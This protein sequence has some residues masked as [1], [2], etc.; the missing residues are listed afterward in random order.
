MK[1]G[2]RSRLFDSL[3]AALRLTNGNVAVDVI[4]DKMLQFSENFSCPYC[5]FT[6]GELEPRI[7]SFNAP[8]GACP[9]CDG[10]GV[11]LEVDKDLVIPDDTKTLNEGAL[12]PWNPISSKY[13]PTMLQQAC[14][15]FGIDMD[16]PFKD[17]P[18]IIFSSS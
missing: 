15:A 2:I 5:G 1:D 14:E 17:L 7:F 10:I 11:K 3:E 16:T 12:A 18:A 13:Y 8:F 4:G 9:D 6:I